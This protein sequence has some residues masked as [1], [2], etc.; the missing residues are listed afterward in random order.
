LLTAYN[1]AYNELMHGSGSIDLT[2]LIP[3]CEEEEISIDNDDHLIT[4]DGVEYINN[5][6]FP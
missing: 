5:V 6:N 4:T 2:E 3:S 1:I